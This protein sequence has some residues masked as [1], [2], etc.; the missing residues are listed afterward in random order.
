[1]RPDAI[2]RRAAN[3]VSLENPKKNLGLDVARDQNG[4][5]T[6]R[7]EFYTRHTF[8][9]MTCNVKINVRKVVLCKKPAKNYSTVPTAQ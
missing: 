8:I 1:M 4:L 7:P 9:K 2:S 5:P 6:S 3:I